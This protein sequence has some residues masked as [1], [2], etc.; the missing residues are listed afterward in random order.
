MA[1]EM[2][3]TADFL[4]EIRGMDGTPNKQG[5]CGE[6]RIVGVAAW[7]VKYEIIYG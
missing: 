4:V 5:R 6:Y 7:T 1:R 2:L 3:R